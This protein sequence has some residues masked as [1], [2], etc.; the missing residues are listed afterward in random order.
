MDVQYVSI[1]STYRICQMSNICTVQ[2]LKNYQAL[3]ILGYKNSLFIGIKSSK[4]KHKEI[5]R[6]SHSKLSDVFVVERETV[7]DM[8]Q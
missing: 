5:K 2:K 3:D 6:L 8:L 1:S 4:N 7:L